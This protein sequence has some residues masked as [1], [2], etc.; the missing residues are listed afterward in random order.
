M[1]PIVN[2][3]PGH[4]LEGPRLRVESLHHRPQR[5]LPRHRRVQAAHLR[6]QN[7]EAIVEVGVAHRKVV[8]PE[9]A[10]ESGSVVGVLTQRL[11]A[12]EQLDEVEEDGVGRVSEG[13]RRF[14][15]VGPAEMVMSVMVLML[16]VVM[17]MMPL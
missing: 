1:N 14:R 11:F 2:H 4:L 9:D 16:M 13:Q 17:V 15:R 5:V 12:Q 10:G 3:D 6:V 7:L 8:E